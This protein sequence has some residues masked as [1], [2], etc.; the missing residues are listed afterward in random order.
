MSSS[1][2]VG[3]AEAQEIVIHGAV[4]VRDRFELVVKIVDDFRQRQFVDEDGPRGAEVFR[5]DVNAAP[6]GAQSASDRRCSRWAARKLMR[7]NRL[8]EL[9]DLAAVGQPFADCRQS[10]DLAS[11]ALRIS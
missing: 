2:Q 11:L 8:A 3:G 1:H 6:F 7:T 5:A 9:L 4:A 10:I